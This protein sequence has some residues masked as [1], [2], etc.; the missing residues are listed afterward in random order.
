MTFKIGDLIYNQRF[1]EYAFYLGEHPLYM[2]WI[3]VHLIS[4]CEKSSVHDC[5]W[6]LV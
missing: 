4:T 5:V 3:R 2:G 1:N 6:E